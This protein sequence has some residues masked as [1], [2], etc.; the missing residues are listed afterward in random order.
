MQL[1]RT[2]L[3]AGD[4]YLNGVSRSGLQLV[5]TRAV[6][7]DNSPGTTHTMSYWLSEP[8]PL[9]RNISKPHGCDLLDDCEGNRGVSGYEDIYSCGNHGNEWKISSATVR[10]NV[11]WCTKTAVMYKNGSD[12][13]FWCTN[14]CTTWCTKK[15]SH[16]YNSLYRFYEYPY[17]F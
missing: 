9:T 10:N 1:S 3:A 14:S 8:N 6:Q 7:R 16:P 15:H 11:T 12:V 5:T 13:Q 17:V 4:S 2:L